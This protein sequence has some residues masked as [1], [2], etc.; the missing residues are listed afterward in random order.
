M[1][2]WS[3]S[4]KKPLN[5]A[6][7]AGAILQMGLLFLGTKQ[8]VRTCST[9]FNEIYEKKIMIC[10]DIGEHFFLHQMRWFFCYSSSNQTNNLVLWSP[11]KCLSFFTSH[12]S[13]ECGGH[14]LSDRWG[15]LPLLRCRF[16]GCIPLFDCFLVFGVL[17]IYAKRILWTDLAIGSKQMRG[18]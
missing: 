8:T 1:L 15:S 5:H 9:K 17:W 11:V 10:E 16:A 13:Q 6:L 3:L 12:E 4:N 2:A 18:P 7:S 14:H